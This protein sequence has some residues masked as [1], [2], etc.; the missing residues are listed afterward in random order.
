MIGSVSYI[1]LYPSGPTPAGEGASMA[2][3]IFFLVTFFQLLLI[4]VFA[5]VF[6]LKKNNKSRKFFL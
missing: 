3:L 1:I 5:I 2:A 4:S 6:A